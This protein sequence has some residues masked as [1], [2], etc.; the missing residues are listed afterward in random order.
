ME[1]A[2]SACVFFTASAIESMDCKARGIYA[3]YCSWVTGLL[4]KLSRVVPVDFLSWGLRA[5]RSNGKAT[6]EEDCSSRFGASDAV[7]YRGDI[8]MIMC[9]RD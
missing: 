5:D 8:Q 1:I 4:S 6:G 7:D 3:V 9:Q 2:V